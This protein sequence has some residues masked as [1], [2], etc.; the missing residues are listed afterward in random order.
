METRHALCV[1]F[2]T[3]ILYKLLLAAAYTVGTTNFVKSGNLI[4]ERKIRLL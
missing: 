2:I 3:N 4:G 1:Y